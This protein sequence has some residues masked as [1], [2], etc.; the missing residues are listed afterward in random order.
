MTNFA[1]TGEIDEVLY[2]TVDALAEAEA[3]AQ[4]EEIRIGETFVIPTELKNAGWEADKSIRV[5]DTEIIVTLRKRRTDSPVD[6]E[7]VQQ[8]IEV[9]VREAIQPFATDVSPYRSLLRDRIASRPQQPRE[10]PDD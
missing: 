6:V 2:P 3:A 7:Q 8:R 1:L 10:P 5:T 4:R 9:A